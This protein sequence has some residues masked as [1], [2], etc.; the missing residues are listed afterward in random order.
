[1][2]AWYCYVCVCFLSMEFLKKKLHPTAWQG[3]NR[4]CLR[5]LRRLPSCGG[6]SNPTFL[7]RYVALVSC[8]PISKIADLAA[9]K[10]GYGNGRKLPKGPAAAQHCSAHSAAGG[11]LTLFWVCG[12]VPSFDSSLFCFSGTC[13]PEAFFFF[14]CTIFT[15]F[16]LFAIKAHFGHMKV[17]TPSPLPPPCSEMFSLKPAVVLASTFDEVMFFDSDAVCRLDFHTLLHHNF[18]FTD[19]VWGFYLRV[20]KNLFLVFGR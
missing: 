12:C 19:D 1:M 4:R 5:R 18:F 3:A 8:V 20:P 13:V 10:R 17:T 15:N 16:T 6:I 14:F 7:L 9:C 11:K 2:W